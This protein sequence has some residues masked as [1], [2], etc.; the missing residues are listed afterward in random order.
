MALVNQEQLNQALSDELDSYEDDDSSNDNIDNMEQEVKRSFEV[1]EK[2]KGKSIED[3]IE[4][5]TN[6]EKEFGRKNNELGELRST[7]DGY[8]KQEL[9]APRMSKE[10]SKEDTDFDMDRFYEDPKAELDRYV[11]SKLNSTNSA[12]EDIKAGSAMERFEKKWPN[13]REEAQEQS[14]AAFVQSSPYRTKLYHLA[15]KRDLDAADEL[16]GL[17][18]EHKELRGQLVQQ[19]AE[20]TKRDALKKATSE[21]GTSGAKGKKKWKR[22]DIRRLKMEKPAEYSAKLPE[23]RQAYAEGRVI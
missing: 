22:S 2:F 7:V 19:E 12:I 23:I 14:F 17:Y 8:I 20:D 21:S 16:Y 15:D 11:A 6:L 18:K 10:T 9:S 4:S 1:P 3:I 5:Y 13:W